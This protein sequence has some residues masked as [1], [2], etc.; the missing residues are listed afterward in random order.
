[1]TVEQFAILSML[2]KEGMKFRFNDAIELADQDFA[3][4]LTSLTW[5]TSAP[6]FS[7]APGLI[8]R[9]DG[10]DYKFDLYKFEGFRMNIYYSLSIGT[11]L[12][13][14]SGEAGEF[15]ILRRWE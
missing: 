12:F 10:M 11:T 14:I 6:P 5:D 2:A 9:Y 3:D 1:M 7:I 8:S 15:V 4:A 13:T